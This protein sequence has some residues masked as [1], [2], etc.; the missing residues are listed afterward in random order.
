MVIFVLVCTNLFF[1]HVICRESLAQKKH[2][3]PSGVADVV[4]WEVKQ[5]LGDEMLVAF[6][7][8]N[9]KVPEEHE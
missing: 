9:S 2:W 4:G 3:V 8:S 7:I 1:V 5:A 6:C